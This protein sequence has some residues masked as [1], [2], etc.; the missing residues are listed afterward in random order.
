MKEKK[1]LV[2]EKELMKLIVK[3]CTS[4]N[5]NNCWKVMIDFL[6][7]KL[8]AKPLDREEVG[9]IIEAKMI[10]TDAD[11]NEENGFLLEEA[12]DI[13]YFVNHLTTAICNLIPE[14]FELVASGKVDANTENEE[15][16]YIRDMNGELI[17]LVGELEKYHG[18]SADIYIKE[19]KE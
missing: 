4:G 17:S 14:G 9:K 16:C 18:K 1:Y 6:S 7:S 19:R 3:C 2:T 8:E 11:M 10:E 12:D 13:N 15:W 5:I